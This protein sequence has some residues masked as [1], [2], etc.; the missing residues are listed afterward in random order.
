MTADGELAKIRLYEKYLRESMEN[1]YFFVGDNHNDV[2]GDPVGKTP[3]NFVWFRTNVNN[4]VEKAKEQESNCIVISLGAGDWLE[5]TT[6]E[7]AKRVAV[8]YIYIAREVARRSGKKVV[9][10]SPYPINGD[11][12]VDKYHQHIPHDKDSI[13]K[14]LGYFSEALKAE[15]EG[16]DIGFIDG[17]SYGKKYL[18]K[19]EFWSDGQ[20]G[21]AQLNQDW[22][23]YIIAELDKISKF[24]V[25]TQ[26]EMREADKEATKIEMRKARE[27]FEA[28]KKKEEEQAR[29][30]AART[31]SQNNSSGSSSSSRGASSSPSSRSSSSSSSSRSSSNSSSSR[32]SSSSSSSRGSSSGSS[33]RGSS[34]GSSSRGSRCLV[35][36]DSI[37][38]GR[39]NVNGLPGNPVDGQDAKGNRWYCK[40]SQ[41]LAWFQNNISTIIERAKDCS[42]IVISLGVNDLGNATKYA[43]FIN[44]LAASEWKGKTIIVTSANPVAESNKYN[45]KNSTIDAFNATLKRELSGGVIFVDTNSA[46]R[47]NVG[48]WVSSDGLHPRNYKYVDDVM[49]K[50][51]NQAIQQRSSYQNANGG[52]SR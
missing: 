39:A 5:I 38:V 32:G 7:K 24:D 49:N 9:F 8:N 19:E 34:S 35:I 2:L 28:Q 48:S 11:C 23:N 10:V 3:R 44:Q 14:Y 6:P 42:Q 18:G 20:H 30:N 4:I 51:I 22:H 1:T 36:G 29:A 52:N 21:N 13:N 26:Y 33:S 50:S 41:G 27:D 46:L 17:Y 31:S 16:T 47:N 37:S 25:V 40:V 43:K 12:E 45:V 15:V